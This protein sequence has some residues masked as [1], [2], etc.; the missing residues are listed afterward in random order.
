MLRKTND[1]IRHTHNSF[2]SL[3]SNTIFDQAPNSLYLRDYLIYTCEFDGHT[4]GQA[5][6]GGMG[7]FKGLLGNANSETTY[8]CD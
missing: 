1:I 4:A 5:Y 3:F 7:R 6:A 8:V 2:G